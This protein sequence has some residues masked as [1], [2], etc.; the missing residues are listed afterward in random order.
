MEKRKKMVIL[1]VV[2][3]DE[4]EQEGTAEPHFISVFSSMGVCNT[5]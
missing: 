4:M 2:L 5:C 3:L 1:V